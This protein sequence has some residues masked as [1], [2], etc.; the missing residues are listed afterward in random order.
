[1]MNRARRYGTLNRS[2]ARSITYALRDSKR[3]KYKGK[4]YSNT[5]KMPNV[6]SA[7]GAGVVL[8]FGIL[9]LGLIIGLAFVYPMLWMFYLLVIVLKFL[10]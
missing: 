6:K 7:D 10:F 9:M 3:N 5:V 1:M 8:F 2:I 4:S